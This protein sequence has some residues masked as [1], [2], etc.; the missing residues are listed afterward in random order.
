M[1]PQLRQTRPP[2]APLLAWLERHR[3][4]GASFVRLFVGGT[5]IYMSQDNVFSRERMLEFERFL[6]ARGVVYPAVAAPLSV[7]AQLAAG[8]LLLLGAYTR[9]AA[10]V[11]VVNF[12][13]ALLVAHVGLP[14]QANIS[15]L[16]M[17]SGALL[18]LFHGAG[19]PS[20]DALLEARRA[21]P[22]RR[23]PPGANVPSDRRAVA[24]RE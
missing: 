2:F 19:R 9:Y 20:V 6:E 8:T 4:Y 12:V 24:L 23:T 10:A 13:A 1:R 3:D 22:L 16:A 15:P 17:L 11:M 5:L 14:Y 7:Y 21:A 18:L